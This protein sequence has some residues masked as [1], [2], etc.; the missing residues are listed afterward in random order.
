MYTKF[1]INNTV[2]VKLTEQGKLIYREEW[3]RIFGDKSGFTYSPPKEDENGYS[4]WQMWS[5][6]ETFGNYMD[7]GCDC[8]FETD[9]LIEF[10]WAE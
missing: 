1:N 10:K 6:M 7:M 4:N 9:I 2:K 3:N 8:P 5:L